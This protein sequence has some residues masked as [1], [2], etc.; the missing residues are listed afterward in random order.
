MEFVKEQNKIRFTDT[1]NIN[2]NLWLLMLNRIN[3]LGYGIPN[4]DMLKEYFD[5]HTFLNEDQSIEVLKVLNEEH[6][7]PQISDEKIA[8]YNQKV[9]NRFGVTTD[10]NLAGYILTDGSMICLSYDG[11]MRDIDHRDIK[12]VMDID[13][14]DDP[15]AAMIAFI[16][17]GNI[18]VNNRCLEIS[19]LPTHRQKE[20]IA[21]F[22]N[23]ARTSDYTYF[24][25]DIANNSGFVVKT[26]EYDYPLFGQVMSDIEAYFEAITI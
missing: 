21:K 23:K 19:K 17:Y 22:I 14:S 26:L 10:L 4:V 11:Y 5:R 3:H 1:S 2:Y 20:V 15:S 7:Y 8:D 25:I 9:K 13:T 16:S 24:A 18:R 6:D 12:E